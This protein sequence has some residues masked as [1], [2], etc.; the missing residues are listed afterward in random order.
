MLAKKNGP[1]PDLAKNWI[2]P[3]DF[4][5]CVHLPMSIL[6]ISV[7]CLF[8]QVKK[9]QVETYPHSWQLSNL[10]IWK[11]SLASLPSLELSVWNIFYLWEFDKFS[12]LKAISDSCVFKWAKYRNVTWNLTFF[13]QINSCKRNKSN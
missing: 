10:L 6:D 13:Q 3:P 1:P 7:I 2:P 5:P 8:F 9:Y 12:I 11:V 4:Q